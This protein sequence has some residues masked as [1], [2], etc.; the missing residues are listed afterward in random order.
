MKRRRMKISG[1]IGFKAI[2]SEH[3][4]CNLLGSVENRRSGTGG[5][6]TE[7]WNRKYKRGKEAKV[8]E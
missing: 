1:K 6:E 3:S 8:D 5:R 2:D 4:T 7:H